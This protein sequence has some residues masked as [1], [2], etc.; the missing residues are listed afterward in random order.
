MNPERSARRALQGERRGLGI[1]DAMQ[2]LLGSLEED[3]AGLGQS[4]MAGA[5]IDQLHPKLGLELADIARHRRRRE[6]RPASGRGETALTDGADEQFH[7]L[8]AIHRS[9]QILQKTCSDY[10]DCSKNLKAIP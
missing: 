9:F 3:L 5:A 1:L 6:P 8:E 10:A 2:H 4:E 7:G